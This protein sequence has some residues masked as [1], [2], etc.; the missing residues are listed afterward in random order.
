[1]T[2]CPRVISFV[3]SH[4]CH[5]NHPGPPSLQWGDRINAF[6]AACAGIVAAWSPEYASRA[7]CQVELLMAHAFMTMG[8][9]VFVVPDG[10]PPSAWRLPGWSAV[11][12]SWRRRRGVSTAWNWN[13]FPVPP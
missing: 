5:Y 3:C 11:R 6:A 8:D 4:T 1:M 10:L 9:K 7:W 12:R 2:P 13:T